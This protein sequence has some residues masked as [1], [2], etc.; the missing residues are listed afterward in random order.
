MALD[1]MGFSLVQVPDG[2]QLGYMYHL[3]SCSR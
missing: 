3:S 1:L 2:F